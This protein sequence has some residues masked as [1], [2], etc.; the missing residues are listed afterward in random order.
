MFQHG[1][2]DWKDQAQ[3][4]DLFTDRNIIIY[5]INTQFSENNDLFLKWKWINKIISSHTLF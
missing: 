5:F 4:N 3:K 1:V 2:P